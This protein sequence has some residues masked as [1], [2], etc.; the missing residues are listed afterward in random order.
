MYLNANS[1]TQKTN[2]ARAIISAERA[3]SQFQKRK[4][5]KAQS[6]DMNLPSLLEDTDL[7]SEETEG[8]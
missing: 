5:F 1:V 4:G 7:N 2:E 3:R 6:S 8:L